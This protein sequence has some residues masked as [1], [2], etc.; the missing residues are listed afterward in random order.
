M[1]HSTE[2]GFPR[3]YTLIQEN[4]II[5]NPTLFSLNL[6][7]IFLKILIRK[8]LISVAIKILRTIITDKKRD[9][10]KGWNNIRFCNFPQ[11]HAF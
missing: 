8:L 1:S 10:I 9:K 5:L 3:T 11:N 6:I 4:P 7:D 2:I